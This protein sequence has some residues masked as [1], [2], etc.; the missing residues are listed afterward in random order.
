MSFKLNSTTLTLAKYVLGCF[1]MTA[2]SVSSLSFDLD[3]TAQKS[4][5]AK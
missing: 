2:I 3:K 4:L 5:C 1:S